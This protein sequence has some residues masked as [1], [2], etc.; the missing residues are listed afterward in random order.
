MKPQNDVIVERVKKHVALRKK[1]KVVYLP[2]GTDINWIESNAIEVNNFG[3]TVLYD[4][5]I[6]GFTKK[7]QYPIF[8]Y[9]LRLDND[10]IIRSGDTDYIYTVDNNVI[11]I[12]DFKHPQD[13]KKLQ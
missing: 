3:K 12:S 11:I 6:Q 8:K 13:V 7:E 9:K 1:V 10:I 2:D 4:S 5:I